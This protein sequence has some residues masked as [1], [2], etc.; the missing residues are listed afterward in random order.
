MAARMTLVYTVP[1]WFSTIAVTLVFV[2]LAV[3]GHVLVRRS[4]PQ[5]DFIEHNEVAG[6]IVAV[7][8]VLYAVLL[9]FMTVVVWEHFS[10]AEERAAEEVNAATDIWRFAAHI[11]APDRVRI[12][13]HLRGYADAVAY[14]EWPKM[15]HG[16]S[17]A[18]AQRFIVHVL[19]DAADLHVA[20]MR[21][22][23]LQNRL[24][25]RVQVMADLRRHRISDNRSGVPAVLWAA[26]VLGACVVFGFI[27]LFGLPNFRVQ[28]MMTAAAAMLIGI[29]FS[30]V[31]ALDYPFRGDVSVSPERWVQLHELIAHR[32]LGGEPGI[33]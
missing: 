13:T 24:L 1:A 6:F 5:V 11:D 19:A 7:V 15:R 22:A 23:N 3:G 28:L 30:V 31:I 16:E 2:A 33:P 12:V 14:D 9:A 21:D 8:G 27:Y 17:S 10:Q 18:I 20:T 32:G 29:S 26:L 4:F 25:D